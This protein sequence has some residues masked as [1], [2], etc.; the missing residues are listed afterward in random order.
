MAVFIMQKMFSAKCSV[1]YKNLCLIMRA[2]SPTLRSL[3]GFREKWHSIHI[4]LGSIR[5]AAVLSDIIIN[6][7][8]HMQ[9]KDYILYGSAPFVQAGA[10]RNKKISGKKQQN[11][12]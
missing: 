5:E 6:Y 11:L 9:M 12:H 10:G 7:F 1:F 4:H 3:K 2:I 8:V